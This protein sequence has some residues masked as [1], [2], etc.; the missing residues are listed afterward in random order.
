MRHVYF[1]HKL[2]LSDY[3]KI[4][5]W[6][7]KKYGSPKHIAIG[8]SKSSNFITW[9]WIRN[10]NNDFIYSTIIGIKLPSEED[11]ML[12]R[13][14]FSYEIESAFTGIETV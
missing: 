1:R 13:L 2:E 12:F 5:E 9:N 10:N 3:N 4:F 7:T 8:Q 6:A 11:E 14:T